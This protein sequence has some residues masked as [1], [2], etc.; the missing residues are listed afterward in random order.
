MIPFDSP[1]RAQGASNGLLS[2]CCKTK[3]TSSQ[4]IDILENNNDDKYVI[5]NQYNLISTV[6][7]TISSIMLPNI[8]DPVNFT[9]INDAIK[10]IIIK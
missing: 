10:N 6:S 4:C 9:T 8:N 2:A 5:F 3:C 1:S 7:N